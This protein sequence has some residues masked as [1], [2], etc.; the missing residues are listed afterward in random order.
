MFAPSQSNTATAIGTS[1]DLIRR[2]RRRIEDSRT[3]MRRVSE[4]N[5]Q[6]TSDA[7]A[8]TNELLCRS[9]TVLAQQEPPGAMPGS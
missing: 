9:L 1:R 6:R 3:Q 4:R 8:R 7:F 2:A 5:L